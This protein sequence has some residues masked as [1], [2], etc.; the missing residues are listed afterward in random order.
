[1]SFQ[2]LSET[3]A[4]SLRDQHGRSHFTR[5]GVRQRNTTELPDSCGSLV[6]VDTQIPMDRALIFCIRPPWLIGK[7]ELQ[8]FVQANVSL[9]WQRWI[10]R[11]GLILPGLQPEWRRDSPEDLRSLRGQANLLQAS[12]YDDCVKNHCFFFCVTNLQ[13]WV[14]GHFVSLFAAKALKHTY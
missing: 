10:F 4:P 14:F 3:V 13:H 2:V 1:M 9:I 7:Q 5:G 8:Q 11:L 6:L 12:I